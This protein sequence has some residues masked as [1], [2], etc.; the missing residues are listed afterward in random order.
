MSL[1]RGR[2]NANES[3]GTFSMVSSPE[4]ERWTDRQTSELS[5]LLFHVSSFMTDV[6]GTT[7]TEVNK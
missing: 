6:I 1:D 5:E 4:M 3:F 7:I 2:G